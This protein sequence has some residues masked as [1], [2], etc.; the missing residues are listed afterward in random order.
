[1]DKLL[2]IIFIHSRL[3]RLKQERI[4]FNLSILSEDI[5]RHLCSCEI[6]LL[7]SEI[8]KQIRLYKL[9]TI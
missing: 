5:L 2:Y 8:I 3:Y 4:N 1:M 9:E 6:E 7:E